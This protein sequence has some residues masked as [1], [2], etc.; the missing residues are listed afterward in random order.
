M[1]VARL[2]APFNTERLYSFLNFF[3]EKNFKHEIWLCHAYMKLPL[4]DIFNLPVSDRR[5]YIKAHNKTMENEKKRMK[6]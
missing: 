6:T 4:S 2:K 1:E 3:D 5:D